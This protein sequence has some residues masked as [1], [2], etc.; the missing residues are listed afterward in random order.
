MAKSRNS[1]ALSM[2]KSVKTRNI[3]GFQWYSGEIANE[4]LEKFQKMAEIDYIIPDLPVHICDVQ[5][6]PP[7]WGLDR[8]DQYVGTDNR[9]RYPGSSGRNVT[10]Y[11]IDTGVNID[12][13]EFEGRASWGPTLNGDP[14]GADRHGHGTFV[15]GVAI[16]KTFGVAKSARVVSIKALRADGSGKLS[17]VLRGIEWI[18]KDHL[19]TPG[20]KTANEAI[21]EAIELG[22]HF[23]IAAG[24][25]GQNACRYSPS[26]VSKAV[27]VGA[28]NRSDQIMGFSNHGSCV[29]IYA[30]GADIVSAWK[31]GPQSSNSLSGTSM[32][33]PHVT[34]A[35]AL[36]LGEENWDPPTLKAN[37]LAQSVKLVQKGTDQRP[38]LH[39]SS[40]F[41]REKVNSNAPLMSIPSVCSLVTLSL[42]YVAKG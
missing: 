14:D 4:M 9:F 12:H 23:S 40:N 17:D 6:K 10:I 30:P 34:G 36:I 7:S 3:G 37:L 27:V 25:E 38:I 28:I 26:S 24:N 2:D 5:D 42:L 20:Q 41:T 39:L 35:M 32:A 29:T 22:I 1:A 11:V 19:R 15:A 21:G 18:V 33:A 16:G 31:S 13:Q 8:I